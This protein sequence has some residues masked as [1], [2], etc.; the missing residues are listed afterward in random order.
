MKN[1]IKKKKPVI[2]TKKL[3]KAYKAMTAS[4]T[5]YQS[6]RNHSL[7]GSSLKDLNQLSKSETQMSQ[8]T[9][10]FARPRKK[11]PGYILIT[12]E[13]NSS[14]TI[15]TVQLG[16]TPSTVQIWMSLIKTLLF[17]PIQIWTR[18]GTPSLSRS[19]LRLEA[20]LVVQNRHSQGQQ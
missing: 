16:C 20:L 13:C 8:T 4:A 7:T 14:I 9:V 6:R 11:S 12:S 1:W 19:F 18:Q 5:I 10:H 3:T 15:V 17:N 2:V